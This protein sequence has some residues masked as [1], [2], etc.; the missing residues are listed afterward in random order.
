MPADTDTLSGVETRVTVV[1]LITVTEQ[2]LPQLIPGPVTVPFPQPPFLMESVLYTRVKVAVTFLFWFMVTVQVFPLVLSHPD[3]L[4]NDELV[5]G[6]AV[7]VTAVPPAR[8]KEQMLPQ[9]IPPPAT[10]PVP[11]PAL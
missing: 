8:F 1:P 11:V 3:Q 2:L 9:L 6:V 5:L 10:V 7:R 4:V